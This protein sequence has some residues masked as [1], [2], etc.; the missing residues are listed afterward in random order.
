M[1]ALLGGGDTLPGSYNNDVLNAEPTTVENKL[2]LVE[3]LKSRAKGGIASRNFPVAIQ[4]YTKAIEV[5]ETIPDQDSATAI[6]YAN[7]SMCRLNMDNAAEALADANEAVALDKTYVKAYYRQTA[8]HKSLGQFDAAKESVLKGLALK[9]DDKEMMSMLAKLGS[10]QESAAKQK[11]TTGK[12]SGGVPAARK[13]VTTTSSA[14]TSTSASKNGKG[15]AQEPAKP[16]VK[17]AP[18]RKTA[19]ATTSAS[20]DDDDDDEDLKSLNLRGYKKTSDGRTTSFFNNELDEQTKALIGNIQPKKIDPASAAAAAAPVPVSTAAAA[21]GGGASSGSSAWNSAGT[22][23]EVILTPWATNRLKELVGTAVS[24]S[25]A[26]DFPASAVTQQYAQEGTG[27]ALLGVDISV[28][29]L[30]NLS[31]DAQVTMARGKRKHLC[32]FS[33]DV[34]WSISIQYDAKLDVVTGKLPV[35]DV[36]ADRDY[37]LGAIEVL[38]LNGAKATS[39]S[40]LPKHAAKLVTDL[41]K[42]KTSPASLPQLVHNA[43]ERFWDELKAK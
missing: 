18:A 2:K 15:S 22:Y 38:Q 17:V 8:A 27:A 7:R 1:S 4:L 24:H 30:E 19:A 31:G 35:M 26:A 40:A 12:S 5:N 43:L 25:G 28:T 13:T 11:K 33:F 41:V 14:S 23:E 21:V 29:G 36:T 42:N 9:P 34:A 39:L 16:P 20:A 10:E 6:L 3:E 32:D 37:E